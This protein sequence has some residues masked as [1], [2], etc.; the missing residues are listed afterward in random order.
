MTSTLAQIR[1]LLETQIDSG[2]TTTATDPTSTILNTYINTSIL[3]I[4]YEIKP[5]ELLLSSPPSGIN[6]VSGQNTASFPSS[7]LVPDCV[8]VL[9]INLKAYEVFNRQFRRLIEL[10]GSTKFFDTNNIGR[11]S[12]YAIRGNSLVFNR[13]FDYSL[14]NGIKIY[15]VSRPDSLTLDADESPLP[16]EYDLLIVYKAAILFYQKD[17]DQQNQIKFQNLA[18]EILDLIKVNVDSNYDNYAYLNSNIFSGSKVLPSNPSFFF[19]S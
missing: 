14:S 7:I 16:Q 18:K 12:I 5:K 19:G 17:D 9:D 8:Y 15:G 11:P 13:Y 4:A 3:Q 10:E 1:S 2:I 6:I